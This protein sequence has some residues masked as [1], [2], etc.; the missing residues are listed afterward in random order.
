MEDNRDDLVVIVAGYDDLMRKFINSNPGL[1]SRFN[2]Y[3]HFDNYS[4]DQMYMI[5]SHLCKTNKYSLD[6]GCEELL[7][8]YFKALIDKQDNSF[9]NAREVRN[10]F[11]K[12]ISNQANRISN[13]SEVTREDYEMIKIED[14]KLIEED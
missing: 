14:L 13:L 7:I 8:N 5:F 3:I 4:A 1:K 9:G 11:E 6:V 10:Y 12:V 2:R